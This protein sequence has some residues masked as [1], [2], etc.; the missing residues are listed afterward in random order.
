VVSVPHKSLGAPRNV[1]VMVRR[2]ITGQK[3]VPSD[4]IVV[5]DRIYRTTESEGDLMMEV[6]SASMG[7]VN[8]VKVCVWRGDIY[9]LEGEGTGTAFKFMGAMT[10][11]RVGRGEWSVPLGKPVTKAVQLDEADCEF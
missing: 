11:S 9:S 2:S 3:S 10:S 7:S 5:G 6:A 4:S 8:G 1:V